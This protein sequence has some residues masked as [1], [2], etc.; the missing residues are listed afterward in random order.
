MKWWLLDRRA[1]GTMGKTGEE[2]SEAQTPLVIE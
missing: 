1:C 2:D